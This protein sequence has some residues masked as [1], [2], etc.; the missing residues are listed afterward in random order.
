[1]NTFKT[2]LIILAVLSFT[3]FP[4]LNLVAN[5]GEI[6]CD[7]LVEECVAENPY[8]WILHPGEWYAYNMGCDNAGSIC[9]TMVEEN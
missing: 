5:D 8:S 9:R 7:E 2:T 1:M 4:N 3:F 6:D